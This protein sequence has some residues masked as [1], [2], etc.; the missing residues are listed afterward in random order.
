MRT[1]GLRLFPRVESSPDGRSPVCHACNLEV[2]ASDYVQVRAHA[3][4][5]YRMMFQKTRKTTA[6]H[7]ACTAPPHEGDSC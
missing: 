2:L 5:S 7:L 4:R 6:Q 1:Y 3:C